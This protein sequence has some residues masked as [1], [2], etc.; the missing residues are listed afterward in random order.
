MRLSEESVRAYTDAGGAVAWCLQHNR[1][2]DRALL[3]PVEPYASPQVLAK[4]LGP[5]YK[6]EIRLFGFS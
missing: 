5:Y 2:V 3:V 4:L 1:H 6:K